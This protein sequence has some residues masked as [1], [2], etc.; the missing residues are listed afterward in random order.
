MGEISPGKIGMKAKA[1]AM[2]GAQIYHQEQQGVEGVAYQ[3]VLLTVI[4]IY[5]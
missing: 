5:F 3:E 2:E 4:I 1:I